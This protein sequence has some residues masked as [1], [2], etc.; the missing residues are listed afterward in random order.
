MESGIGINAVDLSAPDGVRKLHVLITGGAGFIGSHLADHLLARGHCVRVLD[1]LSPQVH[2]TQQ[3][4]PPHTNRDVEFVFGDVRDAAAVRSS[5]A[6][7]DAVVHCAARVGVSLSQYEL[8]ATTSVNILGT[9]VLMEEL[10]RHPVEKLIVASGMAI[11]GEGLY[12]SLYGNDVVTAERLLKDLKA[13]YWDPRTTDGQPLYPVPTPETKRPAPVTVYA[14]TKQMQERLCMLSGKTYEIPVVALR[15][16]NVYG[17]RRSAANPFSG[18]LAVFTSRLLN[19]HRPLVFEDGRQRRDF[20]HVRDAVQA[21]R[22][23]LETTGLQDVAINVGSG[24]SYPVMEIAA[25]LAIILGKQK[26]SAEATG[27]FRV[28]DVRHCFAD[29]TLAHDLLGYRPQVSLD[30]GLIELAE[31]L[32]RWVSAEHAEALKQE[33]G[34]RGLPS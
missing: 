33:N 9:A 23:A 3:V 20:V 22:R 21:C 7:I 1:N 12:H 26:I 2:R 24:Q 18:V 15:F 32:S 16:F 25:K 6:G 4:V 29:I 30:S 5:L 28:S 11:Y 27:A 17:P 8:E 13:G 19:N 31:G 14:L 10:A 34:P